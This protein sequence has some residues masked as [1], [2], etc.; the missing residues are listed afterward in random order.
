M[1][2]GETQR[3]EAASGEEA[4]YTYWAFISYSHADERWA[5]WLH[6]SIETYKVP[7][8][9]AGTVGPDGRAAR[10][11]RLF[12]LFRDREELSTASSL[13]E[14][15]ERA[16]AASRNLIVICSPNAVGSRWVNEEIRTF[17]ALGR[18]GRV[19]CLIVDGEPNAADRPGTTL[20]E[21]F[22]EAVRFT[23]RPDRAIT[24]ERTEPL[25]A[26][27]RPDKDGRRNALLKLSAGL[28]DVGFDSL[29]QRDQ[30]RRIR[31][32]AVAGVLLALL[33][34]VLAGLAYYAFQQKNTAER[35]ARAARAALSGQVASR[36][37]IALDEFPQR[38]LLLAVQALRITESKGEP[39]VSAA[40]E[41]LR[42]ALASTGG[43]VFGGFTSPV[44]AAELS[45][46]GRWLVGVAEKDAA[47]RLWDLTARE[48]K[49]RPLELAGAS[50]PVA[51]SADGRWLA[52]AGNDGL[53]PRLLDLASASPVAGARALQGTAKPLAFTPNGRWLVT[54]GAERDV[55]LWDL[56]ATTPAATPIV[57]AQQQNP[58]IVL[59]LSPDSR[60]LVTSSWNVAANRGSTEKPRLWDLAA[61]RPE[62]TGVEL[63]G[64]TASVSNVVFSPDGRWLATGS[65]EYDT[66]TFRV[67]KHVRLFSLEQRGAAPVVLKGH[68]GPI[69]ALAI[70]RDGRWLA[71]GSADKTARLWDLTTA[72]AGAALLVLPGH[73][74]AVVGVVMTPDGKSIVTID[75]RRG[76]RDPVGGVPTARVWDLGEFPRLT[77][78]PAATPVARDQRPIAVSRST[79]SD[80]GGQLLLV[81]GATAFT[82]DLRRADGVIPL[83]PLHG[84][85]GEITA[86]VFARGG[87]TVVT[88]GQ[89]RTVRVWR[90]DAGPAASPIVIRAELDQTFA[91]SPDSRRLV[92]LGAEARSG[93]D[94]TIPILWELDAAQGT[95][96]PVP[97]RGHEGSVSHV[98]VSRDGRWLATAGR[99]QTARL[100]DLRSPDPSAAPVVLRGHGGRVFR[101]AFT[102]DS[103]A[104][105]TAGD[106]GSVRIWPLEGATAT[107]PPRELATGTVFGI[108]VSADGQWLI[109]T[110]SGQSQ[111]WDLTAKDPAAIAM[112]VKDG[113]QRVLLSP[114]SRWLSA[115][116]ATKPGGCKSSFGR[117]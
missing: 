36:A 29:K 34:V 11:P 50:A 33:V 97:L 61:E 56:A 21:C 99:D 104:V 18:E 1:V 73:D 111:L 79:V 80:D 71:S 96:R 114:D 88:G 81:G 17:K 83:V 66:H 57:L 41:A 43:A 84:H 93:G 75:G 117:A 82:L 22:P 42:R 60:W 90:L 24:T 26:D 12:P 115:A 100:W 58:E 62:T 92:T 35:E 53:P 59:A 64:H 25:A 78:P 39:S 9:I 30:E 46:D 116:A 94:V 101:V 63:A 70:S 108:T 76:W 20:R 13:G 7:K 28:L 4:G 10:P 44:A 106:D 77:A 109:A 85:E 38:S 110:G 23:V 6:R 16:L 74:S 98:A 5:S 107:T 40:K 87:R 113:D 51:F 105:V 48:G 91:I 37:Q 69:T 86:A 72:A 31:Q 8:T 52:V 15:I 3:G 54:G 95:A 49:T 2:D 68:D 32:F 65:A 103:R 89:D 47:G 45:P 27:A 55:R 112:S 19:F 102:P 14:R 67:D